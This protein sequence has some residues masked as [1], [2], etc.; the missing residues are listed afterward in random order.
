MPLAAIVDDTRSGGTPAANGWSWTATS[1]S[2]EREPPDPSCSIL[3]YLIWATKDEY[4][5][6]RVGCHLALA[7]GCVLKG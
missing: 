4:R 3:T 7:S 6:E 5:I 1:M 2:V